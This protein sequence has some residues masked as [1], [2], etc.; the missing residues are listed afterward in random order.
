MR[1]LVTGSQGYI[2]SILAPTLVDAGHEV[3]GL[4]S[5]LYRECPYGEAI[6]EVRSA[7]TF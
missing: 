2:G 5:D 1:V 3:I 4:D 7:R 6:P